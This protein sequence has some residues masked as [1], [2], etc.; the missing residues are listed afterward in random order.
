VASVKSRAAISAV[1]CL[2]GKS[3]IPAFTDRS[4]YGTMTE[5]SG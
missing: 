5:D 4:L 1:F 3:C 2:T